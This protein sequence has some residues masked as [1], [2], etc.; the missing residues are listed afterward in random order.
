L[1]VVAGEPVRAQLKH[2]VDLIRDMTR[3]QRARS[4]R[5]LPGSSGDFAGVF[6]THRTVQ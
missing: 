1:Q 5:L 3:P 2:F 6:G 4:S